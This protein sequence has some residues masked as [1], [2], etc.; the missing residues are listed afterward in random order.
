MLVLTRKCQEKIQIGENITITIVRVKGQT[1]R[2]GIDAPRDLKVLRTELPPESPT[3]EA[4]ETNP[5]RETCDAEQSPL[6]K[7]RNASRCDSTGNDCRAS[8]RGPSQPLANYIPG[9]R[10]L[11]V[12]CAT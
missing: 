3:D 12:S 2:V 6:A 11:A 1:V 9:T 5:I 7:K 10:M 8:H 4:S